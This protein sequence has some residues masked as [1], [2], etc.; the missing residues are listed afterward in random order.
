MERKD[1]IKIPEK[2]P[3]KLGEEQA[4]KSLREEMEAIDFTPLW[5]DQE[6]GALGRLAPILTL[7]IEVVILIVLF[8]K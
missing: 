8:L 3:G 6:Q 7:F 2:L 4:L 5:L 1:Q